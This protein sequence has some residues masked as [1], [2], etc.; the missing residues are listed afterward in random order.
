MTFSPVLILFFLAVVLVL[1]LALVFFSIIFANHLRSTRDTTRS[2]S[3][4]TLNFKLW[5]SADTRPENLAKL[6]EKLF[7]LLA[8]LRSRGRFVDR[9]IYEEPYVGFELRASS[10]LVTFSISAPRALEDHIKRCVYSIFRNIELDHSLRR[11]LFLSSSVAVVSTMGFRDKAFIPMPTFDEVAYDVIDSILH[12]ASGLKSGEV[13]SVQ[14]LCRPA[15]VAFNE[16]ILRRADEIKGNDFLLNETLRRRMREKASRPIFLTNLR[17]MTE[18]PNE[19]RAHALLEELS[20][21]YA[22]LADQDANS[23][24]THEIPSEESAFNFAFHIF[25]PELAIPL[26]TRELASVFHLVGQLGPNEDESRQSIAAGGDLQLGHRADESRL[27]VRLADFE[28]RFS[29]CYLVGQT[30]TGKSSLMINMITQDMR[31][32]RGVAVIDPHGDLVEQLATLVPASRLNDVIYFNPADLEYPIGL[33]MLEAKNEGERDFLVQEMISIFQKLFPSEFVGPI[34][35]HNLRNVLL[36]L[37][38]DPA[39]PGTLAQVPRLLT[40]E[41]YAKRYITR[42]KDPLVRDFWLRERSK[43]SAADQAEVVPYIVSKLGRFIENRLMRNIIG[44]PHSTLDWSAMLQD[45]SILLVNLSKGR[46][47][48]LNAAL[49]GLIITSKLQMA[50]MSQANLPDNQRHD[51]LLYIDEFQNFTTDTIVGILSEARKYHLGLIMAHQF[52]AQLTR[53]IRESVLGNVGTAVVFRVSPDDARILADSFGQPALFQELVNLTN[54]EAF[55]KMS[56]AARVVFEHINTEPPPVG[57][58]SLGEAVKI[59]S[60]LRYGRPRREVEAEV[61]AYFR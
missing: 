23:L 15:A 37:M 49:L 44:Q 21:I 24:V 28:S 40:D 50:A 46:V 1:E 14:L 31:R 7:V 17:L 22:G 45:K 61:A 42:V 29:H 47:G 9:L 27:P 48:E 4:A 51:F 32:G 16:S 59:N 13:M 25:N 26:S 6:M 38:V 60:R 53:P 54:Y 55:V 20:A 35:E 43:M 8:G 18:A 19:P 56:T 30:G 33:N 57:E 12:R 10:E 5:R 52:T 41:V 58:A 2:L 11:T 39:N 36:T 3:L 34:F